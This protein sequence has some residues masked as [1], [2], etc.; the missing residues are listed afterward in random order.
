M[1]KNIC[2]FYLLTSSHHICLPTLSAHQIYLNLSVHSIRPF[3]FIWSSH[4][5]NS[6]SHCVTRP[7][8]VAVSRYGCK[9][10]GLTDNESEEQG[11]CIGEPSSRPKLVSGFFCFHLFVI[12]V[13]TGTTWLLINRVSRS[14][15][16]TDWLWHCHEGNLTDKTT[17]ISQLHHR[18]EIASDTRQGIGSAER[19]S[20]KAILFINLGRSQRC[21]K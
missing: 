18:Y 11:W 4:I 1:S 10:L 9:S 7:C 13:E 19:L 20:T 5:S 8:I 3:C 17:A 14:N 16:M 15:G 2:P 6:I 12:S 21:H